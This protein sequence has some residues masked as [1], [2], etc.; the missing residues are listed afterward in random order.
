M[1]ADIFTKNL[2]LKMFRVHRA[3]LQLAPIS[4]AGGM[5]M[6]GTSR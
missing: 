3:A 5:L 2:S 1:T 6:S 4:E